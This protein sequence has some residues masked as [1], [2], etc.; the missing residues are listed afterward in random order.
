MNNN[1]EQVFE[2]NPYWEENETNPQQI[3]GKETQADEKKAG[4]NTEFPKV[5]LPADDRDERK[6]TS[7]L[8]EPLPNVLVRKEENAITFDV[9]G[10]TFKMIKVEGGTFTMGQPEQDS[11]IVSFT[12]EKPAH[13][14][15]LDSF[16]IGEVTVTQELWKAVF[17]TA[18]ISLK[19]GREHL[20]KVKISWDDCKKFIKRLNKVT[21][22]NFRLPTEAEWEFAAK[23]GVNSKNYKY[24]GT[25]S[26][27]FVA[28][29]NTGNKPIQPVKKL[30]TNELGLYDMSGNVYEWCAD[31]YAKDYYD[32]S[33]QKNPKG[34][35]EGQYR[36][37]RGG[38]VF[39]TADSCR[40][41]MRMCLDPKL[42]E[43]GVGLRLALS[44]S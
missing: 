16:Y 28:W 27:S 21:G 39:S 33:P 36:V 3:N 4:T 15:T 9:A 41:A 35:E 22:Y 13:Q 20:P 17:P 26:L 12:D 7:S 29:Y 24:A 30:K 25:D 43:A 31:W 42:R 32:N 2:N 44:C 6:S 1:K 40:N 38:N 10:E 19:K 23:G 14:V 37:I 5:A 34:P 8:D 18:D 11:K